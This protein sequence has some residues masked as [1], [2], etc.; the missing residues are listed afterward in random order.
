MRVILPSCYYLLMLN[1]K[2][3]KSLEVLLENSII[4]IYREECHGVI[5]S[6]WVTD[7]RLLI[8][9][10]KGFGWVVIFCMCVFYFN[11]I[12]HL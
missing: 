5:Y 12:D 7:V 4:V 8:T 10:I 3:W 2:L 6:G 11:F 9:L 1:S